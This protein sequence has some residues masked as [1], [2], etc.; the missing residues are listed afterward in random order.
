MGGVVPAVRDWRKAETITV[1]E[2]CGIARTSRFH[3]YRL[4][5]AKKIP[6]FQSGEAYRIPVRWARQQLGEIEK[7][8]EG[9]KPVAEI[10][11][12]RRRGEAA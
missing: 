12:A 10:K 2:W 6:A 9:E 11:N 7:N 5:K 3:V 1:D 8:A 4:I